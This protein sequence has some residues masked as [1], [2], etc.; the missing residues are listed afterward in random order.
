MKKV[1]VI[2]LRVGDRLAT[3]IVTHNPYT[4]VRCPKDKIHLG[5]NG[6]LKTWGK[7]TTV[8]IEQP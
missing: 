7:Y 1:K 4:S 8:T 2:D 3:G 6:V 5:V